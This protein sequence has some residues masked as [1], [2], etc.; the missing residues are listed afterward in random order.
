MF[1]YLSISSLV[2]SLRYSSCNHWK[3]AADA[4][5]D[6]CFFWGRSKGGE[7]VSKCTYPKVFGNPQRSRSNGYE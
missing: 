2:R 3:R 7:V 1:V 4:S 5:M 6:E